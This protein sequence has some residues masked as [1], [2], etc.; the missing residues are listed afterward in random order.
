MSQH[1]QNV[2][3]A[4][5]GG[6]GHGYLVLPEAASGPGLVLIQE[7]WGLTE[8][9]IDVARRLAA[10]GF[11]AVAPDLYGGTTTH[12]SAEA[13]RLRR[14][15]PDDRA[16][17]D[18]AGAVDH[19]LGH[20]AVTSRTVGCIGF[21]MGGGFVL[22]MAAQQGDR[23]SAAV[24]FYGLPS[25][26]VDYSGLRA[27]VQGHYALRDKGITPRAVDA[28]LAKIDEQ[29][30]VSVTRFDYNAGH[31]FHNEGLTD[32]YEPE[33]AALAWQRAMAF[34]HDTVR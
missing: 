25:V 4:S 13:Q 20:T 23:V 22:S 24:P 2:T 34:L 32:A 7:W 28:E 19:L 3:F 11:V 16:A 17:R 6:T 14:E 10:E 5:N 26:E 9:I 15:L 1:Q 21:C 12:D 33:A 29:S 30:D 18:L 8:H 27:D 31:A